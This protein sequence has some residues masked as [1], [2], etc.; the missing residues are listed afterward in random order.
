M[1]VRDRVDVYKRQAPT[2]EERDSVY[3]QA[4]E[5]L[6]QLPEYTNIG[7]YFGDIFDENNVNEQQLSG[8]SWFLRGLCMWY[9]ITEDL[10]LIHI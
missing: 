9:E 8:N 5:I 4:N 3:L 6:R 1:T 2:Q 7:G 10:S